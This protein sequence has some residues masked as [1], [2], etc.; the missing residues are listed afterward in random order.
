MRDDGDAHLVVPFGTKATRDTEVQLVGGGGGRVED[1][2]SGGGSG[3]GGGGGNKGEKQEIYQ[4]GNSTIQFVCFVVP[5]M[6]EVFQPGDG[7]SRVKVRFRR[8]KGS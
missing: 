5:G 6:V 8:A 1:G 2:G 3:G 7:R 4:H